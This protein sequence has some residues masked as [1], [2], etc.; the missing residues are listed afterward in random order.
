[1]KRLHLAT[2]LFAAL[3]LSVQ[4]N[5][6]A[7]TTQTQTPT[8]AVKAPTPTDETL[9]KT[10]A[11][12]SRTVVQDI[13]AVESEMQ[14]FQEEITKNHP[15]YHYNFQT[16]RLEHDPQPTPVPTSAPKATA[17]EKH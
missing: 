17:P 4:A 14:G 6:V 5:V 3:A 15:G 12:A 10:E 1:M 7:A 11:I 2:L 16:G 13:N 8:K 9:T